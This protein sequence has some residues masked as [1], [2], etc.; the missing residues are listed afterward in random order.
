MQMLER[1]FVVPFF[2]CAACTS[3][4][5]RDGAKDAPFAR[6]VDQLA[7]LLELAG[8]ATPAQNAAAQF[9]PQTLAA[10]GRVVCGVL[11]QFGRVPRLPKALGSGVW[12]WRLVEERF[13]SRFNES[14]E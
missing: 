3:Q 1:K 4:G 11:F 5:L 10:H 2:I 13:K 7:A 12:H 14:E 9:L 6:L 8:G